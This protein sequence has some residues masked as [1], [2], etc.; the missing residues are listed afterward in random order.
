VKIVPASSGVK[1]F[2]PGV[3]TRVTS[4][5]DILPGIDGR[6][7]WAR[8]LRDLMALHVSDLGGPEAC[9][10]AEKCVVRRVAVLTIECERL[11]RRF[12]KADVDHVSHV[13]VDLYTRVSNTLR[14]LL[15]MTGL[16]RR[17]IDLM[18]TIDEYVAEHAND[19][20]GTDDDII[21]VLP[22]AAE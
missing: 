7:Y 22:E 15:D 2:Y 3:A 17:C 11:E 12:A 4:G 1:R 13:D 6:S 5:R 8:R 16:E 10:E 9:S 19:P 14:R 20:D 21:D 18:P